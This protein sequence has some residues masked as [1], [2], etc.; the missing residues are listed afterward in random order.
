M[1]LTQKTEFK[2]LLTPELKQSLQILSLPL[3]DL[4]SL[5]DEELINNPFLE[6][7]PALAAAAARPV[8]YSR[9]SRSARNASSDEDF[10]PLA[11]LARAPSLQDVLL[12]QLEVASLDEQEHGLGVE[13]IG[14]L[15]DNGFLNISLE[16]IAS[17]QRVPLEAVERV[18]R[19]IQKFEPVGVAARSL[20]ESLLIQCEAKGED[21]PIIK[22]IL[23][24]CLEDVALRR[25]DRI[26]KELGITSNEV[27]DHVRMIAT[28]NPKPGQS[29]SPERTFHVVPDIFIDEKDGEFDIFINQENLPALHI[30]EEYRA[31]LKN[32][33]LA[34]E[35]KAYLRTQLKNA[36][37]FL[38]AIIRRRSTL[39]RVLEVIVGIQKEAL[40]SGL[41]HLRPLT[42]QEVA[43]R[44]GMH[45][46]TVS[47]V[48]MN[49]YAETP[50]GLIA[51]KDLFSARVRQENGAEV[52]SSKCKDLIRDLVDAENKGHPLSDEDLAD[53]L[54]RV[55]GIK[56]ARRT[57]AKYR[58]DL[59]ILSS[60]FRRM[61]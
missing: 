28:L 16:E 48:I 37:E 36:L 13:I 19:V 50:Q 1:N 4:K 42:L 57:V 30:N 35:E 49:K 39:R 8:S 43:D 10:D 6:E 27:A 46:S 51:L 17:G 54:S 26:A 20:Q 59:Q 41:C 53:S 21:D 47:R 34:P 2:I 33:H 23:E 25:Y 55:S 9:S 32:N 29:Y 3:L 60:T 12:R 22:D 45:E 40:L 11:Q 44:I 5:I 18:L 58:E 38:R 15:D 31:I 61:R 14:N 24:R 56:L 52:S 7:S